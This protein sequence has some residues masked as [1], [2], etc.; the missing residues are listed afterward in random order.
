MIL[1]QLQLDDAPAKGK[2]IY[3]KPY[4]L[5]LIFAYSPQKADDTIQS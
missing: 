2:E 1:I 3:I 4:K 5:K